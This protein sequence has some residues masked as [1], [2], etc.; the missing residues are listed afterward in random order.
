MAV[1]THAGFGARS[2]GAGRAAGLV[3]RPVDETLRDVLAWE[4]SRPGPTGP[5]G[6]GLEPDDERDLLAAA[7]D[8]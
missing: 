8:R 3:P 7:Q 1:A 4:L 6:A 2:G 5:H